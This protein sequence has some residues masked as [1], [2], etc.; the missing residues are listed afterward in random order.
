MLGF[1]PSLDDDDDDDDGL[2][3]SYPQKGID[4]G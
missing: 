1:L 3:G 2:N 4:Q